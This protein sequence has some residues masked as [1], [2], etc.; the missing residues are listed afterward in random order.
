MEKNIEK[1]D[2]V[3]SLDWRYATKKFDSAKKVS[4]ADL[5]II[6]ESGRL[7]PSSFGLQPWKFVVVND[8][9]LRE[10][11]KTASYGQAQVT[12]ASNLVVVCVRTDVDEKYVRRYIEKLAKVRRLTLEQLKGFEDMMLGFLKNMP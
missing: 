3:Q 6:L 11:V 12:D 9:V 7:A 10:Q 2:I 8:L 4:D 1:M 5:K